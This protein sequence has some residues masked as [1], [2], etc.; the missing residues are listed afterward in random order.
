MLIFETGLINNCRRY[1]ATDSDACRIL[2]PGLVAGIKV[3]LSPD[4]FR[5]SGQH[6]QS[7]FY[8]TKQA[9]AQELQ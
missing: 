4:N 7:F 2:P 5:G 8:Y 6:Q 1:V 9:G 3:H